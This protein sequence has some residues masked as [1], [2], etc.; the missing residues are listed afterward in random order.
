MRFYPSRSYLHYSDKNFPNDN[1]IKLHIYKNGPLVL[2]VSSLRRG[3]IVALY[4]SK[5]RYD[6]VPNRFSTYLTHIHMRHIYIHSYIHT[7][8]F[9]SSLNSREFCTPE[10][11]KY[12][13]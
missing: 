10:A 3:R 1:I 11:Y 9:N 8:T 6:F 12:Y 2:N 5:S 4:Y 13:I 7:Y